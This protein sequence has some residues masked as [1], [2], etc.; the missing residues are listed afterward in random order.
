[1]LLATKEETFAPLYTRIQKSVPLGTTN[2]LYD[3][4]ND[5]E[6]VDNSGNLLSTY[7]HGQG[8][9]EP[10]AM[11]RAGTVSYYQADAL[12]SV[13]SFRQACVTAAK[14]RC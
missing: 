8:L 10:L 14:S 5:V 11:L 4:L 13:V 12:G 7:S 6:E 1:M 2:Y 3:G 9:D